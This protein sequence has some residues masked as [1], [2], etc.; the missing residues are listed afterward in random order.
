[1]SNQITQFLLVPDNSSARR[2][3]RVLV[4]ESA[5]TGVLV[6]TWMELIEYARKAYLLPQPDNDWDELFHLALSDL[7]DAFW[8]ESYSI[9]PQETARAIN[10]SYCEIIAA[11]DVDA[12]FNIPD[13]KQLSERTRQHLKNFLQLSKALKGAL[14]VD[15]DLSRQ[16]IN[17]DTADSIVRIHV[18]FIDNVPALTRWQSTLLAKLNS[19][20]DISV[21]KSL[22]TILES[23]LSVNIG[24]GENSSLKILQTSLFEASEKKVY[25]D[26]SIQWVGV[27]DFLEE[28]EVAAGMV[29]TMLARNKDLTPAAIGLLVPDSFEYS[30]AVEDAFASA[31]LAVSGLP[32]ERWQRDLGREAVF[33]F[34]YCRQ[35]PAQAM[36]LAVCLS[37]PLMPWAHEE[38]ATLAQ[39]VMNGSYQLRPFHSANKNDCS[40]LDLI[41]EGDEEPKTLIK[42][43]NVFISLLDSDEFADHVLRAKSAVDSLCMMLSSMKVIDWVVLRR[44]VTPDTIMTGASPDFNIE[45]I[46]VL[47]SGYEPWRSV[48]NLIV[49]G[50]SSGNYP[51]TS[52]VSS[53]FTGDEL[54]TIREYLELPVQTPA[55]VLKQKRDCFKRQI[56]SASDFIVFFIP[57]RDSAGSVKAPSESLVFMHQLFDGAGDEPDDMVLNL[58]S[59]IDRKRV[60]YLAEAHADKPVYPWEISA[61]DMQFDCDLLALRTDSDGKQ[62]PESPS[63]METL[64]VSRLAWL[65]RR[66]NAEP[67]GWAPESP[68]VMLLGTLAHQVFEEL[69]QSGQK[70]PKQEDIIVQ[71]PILLDDAIKQH[72]PFLRAAQWQVERRHLAAGITRAAV[73]WGDLLGS[74]KAEI[75]GS[76][77][78]L[79]GKLNDVP[80]HGQADVLLALPENRM[81][82][83]DYKR[84]SS[85]SRRPRMEKGYDSQASLYRTML[86]TGGPKDKENTL[87]T[88][89]LN[90]SSHT[91]I[92][93]YTLNDQIVLSDSVL[94]ESDAIPGWEAL[95]NDISEYAIK[96]IRKR[97][98]EVKAGLL[99]LNR[100]GDE[101]FFNK[102]AGVKPYALESSPL[103]SLFTMPG[104]A[105]E[106]E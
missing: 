20:A 23:C 22:Y 95:E 30:V 81:L 55:D 102:K 43:L 63:G 62:K 17:S 16:L 33:H 80:I 104:E 47:R 53:V 3:R 34:L 2:V 96:L 101:D 97:L 40:M 39:N 58:D 86:Q 103:I 29:Q 64:M 42:A 50:F 38:G 44:A 70:L 56:T 14:P 13:S 4:E 27:R 100:E 18:Y 68:N 85:K 11:T 41:R 5:R 46:T 69:F 24:S 19:D 1:M 60:R 92:V 31:G 99:C 32:V 91:G 45:G 12:N 8:T 83:V 7:N 57:R 98:H 94:L 73:S 49:L 59:T 52:G 74:L 28:A 77:I 51:V 72:G 15:M 66:I 106:A 90:K 105:V 84:S 35:K 82:V 54:V 78:W 21:D 71:V 67:L 75:V 25:L 87:V 48:Q 88:N 37:S 65:L 89:R 61:E 36:A 10:V 9:S 26:N 6:G 76:E 79:E 93:Y